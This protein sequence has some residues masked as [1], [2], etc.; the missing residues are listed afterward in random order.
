MSDMELHPA[1]RRHPYSNDDKWVLF[2]T[3]GPGWLGMG[4]YAEQPDGRSSFAAA[5]KPTREKTSAE[6]GK[7][8]PSDE[9]VRIC[10]PISTRVCGGKPVSSQAVGTCEFP[11]SY[12]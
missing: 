12:R 2:R 11:S 1:F 10:A 8:K 3:Q 5:Q 4:S 7:K 6:T 9:S